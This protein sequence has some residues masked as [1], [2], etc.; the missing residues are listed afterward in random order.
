MESEPSADAAP[1][2][3]L[4]PRSIIMTSLVP[5]VIVLGLREGLSLIQGGGV[6]SL[7]SV[8]EAVRDRVPSVDVDREGLLWMF[9]LL[10]E[11]VLTVTAITF[12]LYFT[13]KSLKLAMVAALFAGLL[14][15]ILYGEGTVSN[16]MA[17]RGYSR[18]AAHDHFRGSGKG[19][20]HL[21]NYVIDTVQ[22]RPTIKPTTVEPI[23]L[24][25]DPRTELP[26]PAKPVVPQA[27]LFTESDYPP[28]ALRQ[29]IGGA[30]KIRFTI[31]GDGRVGQCSAI[32]SSNSTLLG[33]G[34]VSDIRGQG[35]VLAGARCDR[36]TDRADR[37]TESQMADS[38]RYG[39][40]T[41][42]TAG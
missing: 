19:R 41:T 5:I 14:L 39:R 26:R 32:K 20:I 17:A 27:A 40:L 11:G 15:H 12:R 16:F 18:C 9:I 36:F 31:G 4:T 8:I 1:I 24:S 7:I 3:H 13:H 23:I 37:D 33:H 10:C 28:E 25:A 6:F 21:Q 34:D 35:E 42:P 2:E 30:V 38:D 29:N 22:C